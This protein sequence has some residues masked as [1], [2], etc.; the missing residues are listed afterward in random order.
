MNHGK[1]IKAK[2]MPLMDVLKIG[3][4]VDVYGC[5]A[6][7]AQHVLVYHVNEKFIINHN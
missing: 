7:Y 6:G 4:Q 5:G 1:E 3:D 2:A